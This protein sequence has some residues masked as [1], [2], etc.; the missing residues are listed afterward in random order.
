[1]Y[2]SLYF[3]LVA[4]WGG[5]ER[6][7]F[8]HLPER[9]MFL[10]HDGQAR[11]FSHVLFIYTFRSLFPYVGPWTRLQRSSGHIKHGQEIY[12]LWRAA[13]KASADVEG[14]RKLV[15]QATLGSAAKSLETTGPMTGFRVGQ[16]SRQWSGAVHLP[17]PAPA[18]KYEML[19]EEQQKVL[20]EPQREQAQA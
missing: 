10:L 4:M 5:N 8:I 16:G 17:P 2:W 14:P 12:F 13:C 20:K 15:R 1:M 3:W 7:S 11:W 9:T 18:T 19:S 6:C